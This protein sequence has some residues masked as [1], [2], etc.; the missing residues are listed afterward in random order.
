MIAHRAAERL[1]A[2]RQR[3]GADLARAAHQHLEVG[4]GADH[5]QG[6]R[7]GILQQRLERL[8]GVAEVGAGVEDEVGRG[9]VVD[10]RRA[11]VGQ[12]A[13]V[14]RRPDHVAALAERRVPWIVA[15]N[16]MAPGLLARGHEVLVKLARKADLGQPRDRGRG[17]P[18]RVRQQHD[19]LAGALQRAQALDRAGQWLG[20]VVQHAPQIDDEGIVGVDHGRQALEHP[21]RHGPGQSAGRASPNSAPWPKSMA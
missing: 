6:A 7:T 19:P 11:H 4:I 14:A 21:D 20:A 8:D 9:E 2:R 12:H 5:R 10:A 1:V 15:A 17:R 18:R 13:E 3:A 16:Q